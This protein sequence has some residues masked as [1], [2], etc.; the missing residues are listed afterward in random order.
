[1]AGY[2]PYE[3]GPTQKVGAGLRAASATNTVAN[4]AGLQ[5]IPG[6]G[7][8]LGLGNLIN[9]V[10]GAEKPGEVLGQAARGMAT[11]MPSFLGAANAASGLLGGATMSMLPLLPFTLFAGGG[12]LAFLDTNGGMTKKDRMRAVMGGLA[13]NAFQSAIDPRGW[14]DAGASALL[15][16]LYGARTGDILQSALNLQL[17]NFDQRT[18]DPVYSGGGDSATGLGTREWSPVEDYIGSRKGDPTLTALSRKL[19]E[20]GFK[21]SGYDPKGVFTRNEPDY[22][23]LQ[24]R[25]TSTFELL[26]SGGVA[27]PEGGMTYSGVP[28][29][30]K[31]QA[32]NPWMTDFRRVADALGVVAAPQPEP[33][34][35]MTLPSLYGG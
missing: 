32:A 9:S 18:K 13:A 12:P 34:R 29:Y 35:A 7:L 15:R 28:D 5:T 14:G 16:P 2:G 30:M 1:M 21:G 27:Q 4:L 6:L 25:S 24:P 33:S 31:E 23:P 19:T 26:S 22:D 17:G 3:F 20:M 11:S 10:A 8:A